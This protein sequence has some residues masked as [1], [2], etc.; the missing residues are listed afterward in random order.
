MMRRPPRSTLFPY[1]TL[2]R[3]ALSDDGLRVVYSARGANGAT[4][5][6]LLDGRNNFVV[7]QLTQLGTR[8]SDVPLNASIS[9]DG[10]RVSFATR[11]SVTGGN[12]DT[13]AEVYVYDI[14]TARTTRITNA[15]AGATAEVV[16][17]LNDEG[18]IGRAS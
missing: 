6:F 11:R 1:T 10:D 2:F 9:G 14:P 18:K 15:P 7:R 5:V 3:S 8:A 16:S 12:S 13:S 17:S 4:Q